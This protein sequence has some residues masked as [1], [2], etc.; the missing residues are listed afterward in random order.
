MVERGATP[1]QPTQLHRMQ[2]G[3]GRNHGAKVL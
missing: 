1:L 3:G 2:G